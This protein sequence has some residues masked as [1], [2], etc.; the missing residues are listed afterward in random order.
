M[1]K[2]TPRHLLQQHEY[3]NFQDMNCSTLNC[4]KY[5]VSGQHIPFGDMISD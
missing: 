2:S 3:V 5:F 4:Y 1:K